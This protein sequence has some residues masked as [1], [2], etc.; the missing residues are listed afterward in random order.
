MGAREHYAIPRALHRR[1]ALR[2]LVTEAWV[3][4]DNWL[5]L[6]RRN[7]R[8]RFHPELG[9]AAVRAGNLASMAFEL[10][11]KLARQNGW[12]L[13]LARNRWFQEQ[14]IEKLKAEKLKTERPTLFAYSYAAR[15]IFQWAKAQGWRTVLGQIDPGLPEERLVAGLHAA[16]PAAAPDW[17][18]APPEYW[19][20]WRAECELA[21]D[22]VVNSDWSRRALMAEGIPTEKIRVIP[23]AYAAPPGA[24]AFRREVPAEFSAARPLRVLFLGQINLRKGVRPLLD[25]V[26]RLR[27]VPVEFWLVGPVQMSV[28]EDLQRDPQVRWVGSVA[29][30]AAAEFYRQA[31]VFLFPTLSDGF[32]LTQLEAQAWQ[33]PVIASRHCGAVVQ[34]GVNGL[35]LPEV[36]AEAIA[37]MILSLIHEP[38]RLRQMSVASHIGPQF[39]LEALTKA[40]F[41]F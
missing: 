12:P 25:A 27:G 37:S 11:A 40:L 6:F 13:I 17:Q 31:D 41:Q 30:G 28:P 3:H 2:A 18:C 1:G 36:S 20:N 7:L 8:E 15:E 5:G 35:L 34:D 24:A 19:D 22:I 14:A 38:E 21:D 4:P 39:S 26:R 33:L 29:R 10:R 23:L 9:T 16:E 32:G